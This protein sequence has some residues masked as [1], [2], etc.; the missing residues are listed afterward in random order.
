MKK[1]V[2]ILYKSSMKY[3]KKLKR[4]TLIFDVKMYVYVLQKCS[5]K[6]KEVI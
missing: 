2:R 6:Y 3:K 1:H 5:V 4:H